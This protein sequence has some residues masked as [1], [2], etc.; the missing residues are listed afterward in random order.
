MLSRLTGAIVNYNDEPA[1]PTPNTR[2]CAVGGKVLS[3]VGGVVVVAAVVW[4]SAF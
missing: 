4:L 2:V 3:D 1:D